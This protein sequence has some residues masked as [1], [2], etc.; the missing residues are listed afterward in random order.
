M[1]RY[2]RLLSECYIL[3]LI[4]LYLK[5]CSIRFWL[6]E[7]LQTLNISM[8]SLYILILMIVLSYRESYINNKHVL[9][10]N[11]TFNSSPRLNQVR[12]RSNIE[13]RSA[14]SKGQGW[15]LDHVVNTE[16]I[17]LSSIVYKS[18]G[19]T[20]SKRINLGLFLTTHTIFP[21]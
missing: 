7:R 5:V 21:G 3:F 16:K 8:E 2:C 18:N 17:K 11:K 6:Q 15:R 9:N 10:I 20:R 19:F 13:Q 12:S 1:T 14:I 4:K